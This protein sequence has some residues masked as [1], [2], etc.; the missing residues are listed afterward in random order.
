M[1]LPTRHDIHRVVEGF[2]TRTVDPLTL[3]SMLAGRSYRNPSARYMRRG[4]VM[5]LPTRHDIHRVVEGFRTRTVDPLTLRSNAC[6]TI[7]P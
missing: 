7:L 3:R 4:I 6:G 1:F 2:R 5:F